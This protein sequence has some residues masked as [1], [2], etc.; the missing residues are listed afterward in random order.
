MTISEIISII[1][2]SSLITSFISFFLHKRTER[3]TAEVKKDFELLRNKFLT[4]LQWK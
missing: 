3:I 1:L 2:G 4:D